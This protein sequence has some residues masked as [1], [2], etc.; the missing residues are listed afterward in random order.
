MKLIS[1]FHKSNEYFLYEEKTI[2]NSKHFSKGLYLCTSMIIFV[3]T[4]N[5]CCLNPLVGFTL[6]TMYIF[7]TLFTSDGVNMIR[8]VYTFLAFFFDG[9]GFVEVEALGAR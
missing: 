7:S 2:F 3:G 5:A 8:H 9:F 4:F 1:F 6:L